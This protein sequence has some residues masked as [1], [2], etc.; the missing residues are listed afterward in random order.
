VRNRLWKK[1]KRREGSG[2]ILSL[3][4]V[5]KEEKEKRKVVPI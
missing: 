1:G 5:K 2:L 4:S 3:G